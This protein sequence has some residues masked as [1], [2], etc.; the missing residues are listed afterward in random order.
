M[1]NTT[2]P[3]ITRDELA[4][5]RWLAT[6]VLHNA[7][8]RI[9]GGTLDTFRDMVDVASAAG[10]L[11]G[12]YSDPTPGSEYDNDAQRSPVGFGPA[13]AATLLAHADD[14]EDC[15]TV[16]ASDAATYDEAG[17][18][19]W[20]ACSLRVARARQVLRRFEAEWAVEA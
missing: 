3:A 19:H 4:D 15:F 11:G 17:A 16:S 2:T 12:D 6:E 9:E 8:T 14:V 5:L 7:V 20:L 1:S 13:E 10:H 18:T